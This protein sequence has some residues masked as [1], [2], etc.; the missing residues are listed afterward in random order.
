MLLAFLALL[1]AVAGDVCFLGTPVA[2][3]TTVPG[4][5]FAPA[6]LRPIF[7]FLAWWSCAVTAAVTTGALLY[8]R[9][10]QAAVV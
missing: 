10:L 7:A 2:A 1:L 4:V 6:V 3:A 8:R 5:L 9:T